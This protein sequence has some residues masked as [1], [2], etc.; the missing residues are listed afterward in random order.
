MQELR[1]NNK[2]IQAYKVKMMALCGIKETCVYYP[3]DTSLC[4][5]V[6]Q[7]SQML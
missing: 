2:L 7:N 6:Y 5:F 3:L 4:I 1:T